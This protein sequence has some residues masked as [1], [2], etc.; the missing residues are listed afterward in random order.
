VWCILRFDGGVSLGLSRSAAVGAGIEY[1]RF[2]GHSSAVLGRLEPEAGV[3]L[4][5]TMVF[6]GDACVVHR[7]GVVAPGGPFEAILCRTKATLIDFNIRGVVG[8]GEILESSRTHTPVELTMLQKHEGTP[9]INLVGGDHMFS[10][11]IPCT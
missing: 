8:R 4:D 7:L 6:W 9:L 11:G 1:G 5:A 10:R 2:E 3:E